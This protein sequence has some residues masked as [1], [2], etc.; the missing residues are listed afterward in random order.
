MELYMFCRCDCLQSAVAVRSQSIAE[1]ETASEN[2]DW[3]AVVEFVIVVNGCFLFGTLLL[4]LFG[5]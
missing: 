5:S 4:C 2:R 1:V 3:F